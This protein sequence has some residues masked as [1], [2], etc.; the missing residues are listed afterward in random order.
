VNEA[1]AP[2]QDVAARLRPFIARRV[3]S[4]EIDDVMQDVF[5]RMQR[6]LPALREEERFTSCRWR[7]RSGPPGRDRAGRSR[8]GEGPLRLR[9]DVRG[10]A[11]DAVPRGGDARRARGTDGSRGGRD[12]R[13]LDL[14]HEVARAARSRTAARAVRC[15]LRDRAR[16]PRQA[17]RVHPSASTGVQAMP[18]TGLGLDGSGRQLCYAPPVP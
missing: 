7:R 2:W 1:A 6:G 16:R 12:G 10:A 3:S 17:D 18:V 8:G 11:S 4:T 13:D 5:V 9:L 14:R 15:L